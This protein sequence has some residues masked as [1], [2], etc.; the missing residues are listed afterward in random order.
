MFLYNAC[1]HF[2]LILSTFSFS[3]D[4]YY[5]YFKLWFCLFYST[6]FGVGCSSCSFC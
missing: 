1:L 2:M 3:E 5:T 6:L 4:I